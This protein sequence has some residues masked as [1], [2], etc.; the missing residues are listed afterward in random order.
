[1]FINTVS[2]AHLLCRAAAVDTFA[3]SQPDSWASARSGAGE[4]DACEATD[5]PRVPDT[6]ARPSNHKLALISRAII[7]LYRTK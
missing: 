1:M 2:R 7:A 6:P 4:D 3:A 5:W